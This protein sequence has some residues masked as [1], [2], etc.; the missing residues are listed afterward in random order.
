MSFEQ[1][2]QQMNVMYRLPINTKPTLGVGT[3][4]DA[5]L[6]ARLDA[7][8][9]R[10]NA[11]KATLQKELNEAD[12]IIAKL[13][14]TVHM[15]NAVTPAMRLEDEV[16]TEVRVL[17]DIADWFGDIVV[18]VFS[19]AL[20][21]GIPPYAVLDCIME[22][23]K[24]KLDENGNPIYDENGKFLKGPNFTPPE[25]AIYDLLLALIKGADA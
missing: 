16:F 18:Y 8:T 17:T 24:T 15:V 4:P 19:E 3:P 10:L 11:F 25:P 6:V 5:S 14:N 12:D 2:I 20:K 1:D 21:F 9:V 22:S 7:A 13:Q 23:N